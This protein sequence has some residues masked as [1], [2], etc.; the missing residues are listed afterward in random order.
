MK[1]KNLFFCFTKITL[2]GRNDDIQKRDEGDIQE[3]E[4]VLLKYAME[5]VIKNI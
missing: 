2:Q 4:N 5:V 1:L 3:P